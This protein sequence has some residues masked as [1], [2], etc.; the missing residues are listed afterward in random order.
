MNRTVVIALFMGTT[1]ASMGAGAYLTRAVAGSAADSSFAW[2]EPADGSPDAAAYRAG[3]N[4][5]R[6]AQILRQRPMPQ[7]EDLLQ[8]LKPALREV[9]A[10]IKE[11]SVGAFRGGDH[12]RMAY[13]YEGFAEIAH[14]TADIVRMQEIDQQQAQRL[15]EVIRTDA[16]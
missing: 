2:D 3:R 16:P 14:I 1:L 4:A 10:G 12:V 13:V 9:N 7:F 6:V 15:M 11:M 8:E 5:H